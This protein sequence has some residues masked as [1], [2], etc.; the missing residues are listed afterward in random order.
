[1]ENCFFNEENWMC[2]TEID[3]LC[4]LTMRSS[5]GF[6]SPQQISNIVY[7][8]KKNHNNSLRYFTEKLKDVNNS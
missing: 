6:F 5:A 4:N 2:A 8:E 1:M 7:F 3:N